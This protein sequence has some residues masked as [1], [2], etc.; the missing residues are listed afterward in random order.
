MKG[1]AAKPTQVRTL[2]R[3]WLECVHQACHSGNTPPSAPAGA[4]AEVERAHVAGPRLRLQSTSGGRR[5]GWQACRVSGPHA[6]GR[7]RSV[8]HTHTHTVRVQSGWARPAHGAPCWERKMAAS[9]LSIMWG[10]VR[11]E[12]ERGRSRVGRRGGRPGSTATR[13]RRPRAQTGGANSLH[14][15]DDGALA[16]LPRTWKKGSDVS[17]RRHGAYRRRAAMTAP[18]P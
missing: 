13:P 16:G 7:G 15:L 18:L 10:R 1:H 2:V 11:H 14:L 12:R 5:A 9:C 6:S 4:A 8:T 3:V 17:V